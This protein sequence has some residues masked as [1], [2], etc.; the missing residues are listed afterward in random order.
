M[1]TTVAYNAQYSLTILDL[2]VSVVIRELQ[3]WKLQF[4]TDNTHKLKI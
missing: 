3:N 2:Q 4:S 1:V